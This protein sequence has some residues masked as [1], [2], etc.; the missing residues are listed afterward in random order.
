MISKGL[1]SESDILQDGKIRTN[2]LLDFQSWS[3]KV[4]KK[5]AG[6]LDV[7]LLN[8][9]RPQEFNQIKHSKR[10]SKKEKTSV[11]HK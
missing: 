3:Q 9:I 11:P 2:K 5:R 10:T 1:E 6:E 8:E 7:K 4:V